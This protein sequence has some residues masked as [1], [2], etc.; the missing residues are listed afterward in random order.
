[1]IVDKS[2]GGEYQPLPELFDRVEERTQKLEIST[3]KYA[4][5]ISQA[6]ASAITSGKSFDN[7]LKSLALRISQMAV[8]SAMR[9][10]VGGVMGGLDKMLAGLFGGI[11]TGGGSVIA[12][13][14]LPPAG[15]GGPAAGPLSA[16]SVAGPEFARA[17][18]PAG[19]PRISIQISTPDAESFRRSEA[20]VTGQIARA[21]ARGQRTF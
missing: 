4:S 16:S 2:S 8:Q 15:I 7:V 10:I 6:F 11:F 5:A 3:K 12:P 21:V 19:A 13:P 14:Y 1:M 17:A 9:P 20:Y 18:S